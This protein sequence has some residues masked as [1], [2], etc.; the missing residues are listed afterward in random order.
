[1]DNGSSCPPIRYAEGALAT[2]MRYT[3]EFKA[4]YARLLRRWMGG[5]LPGYPLLDL[6]T[7]RRVLGAMA[8]LESTGLVNLLPIEGEGV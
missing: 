3:E 8:Q 1:M 7:I 4:N 2:D 5:E 6:E